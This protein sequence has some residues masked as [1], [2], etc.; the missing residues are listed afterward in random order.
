[1]A[2]NDGTVDDGTAEDGA[3][4]LALGSVV[5]LNGGSRRVMVVGRIQRD[6]ATGIICDYSACPWPQGML[7]SSHLIVFNHANIA[8]VHA[9]GFTDSQET[10]WRRLLHELKRHATQPQAPHPPSN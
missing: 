1:M 5:T 9:H 6:A 2:A 8:Q 4:W 10:T 7:D 3:D